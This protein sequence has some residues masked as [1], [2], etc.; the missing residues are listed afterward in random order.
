MLKTNCSREL[1]T[2]AMA[3]SAMAT[4]STDKILRSILS[5]IIYVIHIDIL[6]RILRILWMLRRILHSK[7]RKSLKKGWMHDR[8]CRE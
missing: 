3:T 4:F 2:S 8:R 1:A 6:R 5:R 7:L